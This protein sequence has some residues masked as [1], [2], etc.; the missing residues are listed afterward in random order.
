MRKLAFLILLGAS[1]AVQPHPASAK[2]WYSLTPEDWNTAISMTRVWRTRGVK[3]GLLRKLSDWDKRQ[4]MGD[5][6]RWNF[7]VKRA[8]YRWPE[9]MADLKAKGLKETGQW[10]CFGYRPDRY[11][12]KTVPA[13]GVKVRVAVSPRWY[14]GIGAG[15]VYSRPRGSAWETVIIR[16][17]PNASSDTW[18]AFLSW[19][20][21]AYGLD[22]VRSLVRP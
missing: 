17:G 2:D 14:I 11:G 21:M 7:P 18:R 8:R 1:W 9:K 12:E 4:I 10:V 15:G 16:M 22:Y 20:I 19:C 5:L 13:F 6:K 3:I